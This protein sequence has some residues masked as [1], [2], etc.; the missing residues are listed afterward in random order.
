[1][2]DSVLPR[3]IVDPIHCSYSLDLGIYADR[4]NSAISCFLDNVCAGNR[5]EDA[6]LKFRITNHRR[7]GGCRSEGKSFTSARLARSGASVPLWVIVFRPITPRVHGRNADNP[8]G[9]AER[10]DWGRVACRRAGAG[11]AALW[12]AWRYSRLRRDFDRFHIKHLHCEDRL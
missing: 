6:G 9:V 5:S 2:I 3:P 12:R 8:N 7:V 10:E 4:V 11:C 1:M